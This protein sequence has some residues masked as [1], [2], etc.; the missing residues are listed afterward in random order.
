[1]STQKWWIDYPWRMVQ[2]NMRQI[3]WADINAEQYVRDLRSFD[4]TVV[5]LNASGIIANYPVNLDFEPRNL[6]LT[7]DSIN[8]IIDACHDAGIR[9]LA[10]TDYSKIREPVYERHPDWAFRDAAGNIINYNGDVHVCPNGPYQ[11]EYMFRIIS[12]M[13]SRLP[14]DGIFYN[15]GGFQTRD[16]SH[17]Y[18]G[19]CHCENCKRKFRDRFGQGPESGPE[20][21]AADDLQ[22]PVYRKYKVFQDECMADLNKRLIAHVRAISEDIAI[23]GIDYQRIESNTELGRPLPQWQYSASSNTRNSRGFNYDIIPSNTSVDFIGFSYRH[24][25][26]SPYQQELRMWQNL[27]NLGAVDYY[28]IGR[29]DNHGDRS[30]FPGIQKVFHFAAENYEELKGLRNLAK[31]LVLHKTHW[32][33]DPEARGWV[34][35]LTEAHV[36]LEEAQLGKLES[37]EQLSPHRLVILPDLKYISNEQAKILDDYAEQGGI[38][39]ATGETGFYDNYYERRSAIPLKSL[40]IAEVLCYRKDVLSAMF[41]VDE[42]INSAGHVR[43]TEA[44]TQKSFPHFDDVRYIACGDEYICVRPE[45]DAKSL[46][47]L[48]PPQPFGP[49]ERCYAQN[50]AVDLPALT[51]FPFGKGAGIYVPWRPG[52]LFYREGYLNTAWFM[53]DVV[54]HICGVKNIAPALNPQVE[55]TLSARPAKQGRGSRYMV[56]QLVNTSGHYGNSFYAPLPVRDI[57]LK[58]PLAHSNAAAKIAAPKVKTVRTLRGKETL[59]WSVESAAGSG[60]AGLSGADCI[61]TFTLPLLEEYE[62]IVIEAEE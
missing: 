62:G 22:N 26:V 55:V 21:P 57:D 3:D 23:D 41:L 45:S 15:M 9:V 10:R 19:L 2:T 17:T 20:L 43:V 56:A 48:L 4:A 54:E 6:Y 28:L 18:H 58:I 39:L 29:L 11:Q 46:L 32:D 50:P 40:G 47:P 16:Y 61:I 33:D 1:M 12:D 52:A 51:R 25:S 37:L 13:F 7:G 34:R 27:A 44:S 8:K 30:S 35:M 59:P 42:P 31:V 60:A 24:V 36:P 14:F 53:Q 49:P 5:L 38:V